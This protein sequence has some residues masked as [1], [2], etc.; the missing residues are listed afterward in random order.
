MQHS[1]V[2]PVSVVLCVLTGSP[3]TAL[4]GGGK[5]GA[6]LSPI[7]MDVKSDLVDCGVSE[8]NAR[9]DGEHDDTEALQAAIDFAA[10]RDGGT[11]LLPNGTYSIRS[12]TLRDGVT[13]TGQD[14]HKTLLRARD[15]AYGM[16]TIRGGTL[17]NCTVYGTPSPDVSGENWKVGSDGAGKGS[18]AKPVH[19]VVVSGHEEG[20][21]AVSPVINN[22][23][24]RE[25]RYDCLY[26]RGTKGLRVLDST[27]DRA[28]RNVVS[29]VGTDE[30][31]VFANCRIGGLW[32]LYHF[33]IEP[34][35]GRYVRGG[36]FVNCLFD[37]RSAG[38][39]GTGTWGSFVCFTGHEELKSRDIAVIG[40]RF[41]R[42]YVRVNRV[43]PGVSF[44]H[45]TF[46]VPGAAF[47]RVQTNEVGEFRDAVVR[48]NRFLQNGQPARRIVQGVA[49]TGKSR[50]ADNVPG[51]PV[52]TLP[53][54]DG[55]N[56]SRENTDSQ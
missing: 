17:M 12:V 34:A 4:A 25:A 30:D 56:G 36:R 1:W 55:R 20:C 45:N 37:G 38:Q 44:L 47:V 11:I 39:M 41:R 42:I 5:A 52:K 46:D 9:G 33:D 6:S 51:M 19:L 15:A 49:F 54:E 21:P 48:G 16:I 43:F 31:F 3:E 32:G 35:G 7:V 10:D 40:C 26:I 53:S 14:P 2:V 29:M 23:H 13:L 50:F 24:L 22:V 27:F 8:R 18:T 28:G